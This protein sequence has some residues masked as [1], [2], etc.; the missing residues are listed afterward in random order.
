MKKY[1]TGIVLVLLLA[2]VAAFLGLNRSRS[3][4]S[5]NDSDFSIR[6]TSTV[7]RFFLADR[8][9]NSVDIQRYT[10]GWVMNGEMPVRKEGVEQFLT[11]MLRL[12]VSSP[13]AK[14]AHDNVVKR[15]A[16][17]G[18]KVEIYQ[19]VYRVDLPG[20]IRLFP[21]EKLTR[22]FYVGDATQDNLGT[23]MMLEGAERP[24][25]TYIPGFRGFVSVR[26]SPRVRDWR[27]HTIFKTRL[28]D[29][30]RVEMEVKG[31]P[32]ESYSVEVLSEREFRL[33]PASGAMLP[34]VDTLKLVSYLAA[35]DD[36]RYEA[37]LTGD[38]G[39]DFAD[40][41]AASPVYQV[42][43][44]TD[45]QGRQTRVQTHRRKLAEPELDMNG[46]PV[47]FDR[48]R[49]YA[50]VNGGSDLV[51]VQYFV[52][53]RISRPIDWFLPSAEQGMPANL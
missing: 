31:K 43:T 30:A 7:T 39:Q 19:K 11:T 42:I 52:F 5:A 18:V 37:L 24:Y 1:R 36:I 4:M 9:G 35:F 25:I 49:M 48:D 28:V 46:L 8:D 51:L 20:N 53:S 50:F 34:A 44:L 6:D 13:V 23:Y 41:V 33:T 32:E 15:L 3:T 2:L 16:A 47:M 10:E 45:K 12:A 27:D 22:T 21:H 26:F 40:S 17:T 29:I 14:S 38:L